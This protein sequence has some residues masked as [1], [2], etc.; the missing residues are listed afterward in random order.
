MGTG[1]ILNCHPLTGEVTW[2]NVGNEYQKDITI[3]V[4]ATITFQNLSEVKC[5]VNVV[6]KH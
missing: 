3:P 6:F 2:K 1:S 4:I 5:K